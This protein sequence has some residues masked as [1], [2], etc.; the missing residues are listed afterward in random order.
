MISPPWLADRELSQQQGDVIMTYRLSGYGR[1]L[2][3]TASITPYGQSVNKKFAAL[4]SFSRA[5]STCC[6]WKHSHVTIRSEGKWVDNKLIRQNWCVKLSQAS[7]AG[8]CKGAASGLL[9]T[10]SYQ[11]LDGYVELFCYYVVDEIE[12]RLNLPVRCQVGIEDQHCPHL[13]SGIFRGSY[14]ATLTPQDCAGQ[15]HN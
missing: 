4:C 7:S 6:I 15:H 8:A 1:T 14:F 13:N 11:R 12:R 2:F 5:P 10:S 9:D 3:W